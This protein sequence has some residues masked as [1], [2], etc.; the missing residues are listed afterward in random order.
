MWEFIEQVC[1]FNIDRLHKRRP[2]KYFIVFVLIR[3]TILVSTDKIQKNCFLRR[4]WQR[5]NA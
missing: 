2:K 1:G 4:G 5:V 3:P